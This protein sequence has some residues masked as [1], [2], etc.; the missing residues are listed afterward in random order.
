MKSTSSGSFFV[1]KMNWRP[2]P[3]C[4]REREYSIDLV[5]IESILTTRVKT[6][7]LLFRPPGLTI[8][9]IQERKIP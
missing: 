5:V 2:G 8:E 7:L 6:V 1:T 4:Y 9:P 3:R